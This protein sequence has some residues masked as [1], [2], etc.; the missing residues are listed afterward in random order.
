[1]ARLRA[2]V[3]SRIGP[4]GPGGVAARGALLM[5]LGWFTLRH[6]ADRDFRGI[7]AGL[8][9]ALHEAGHLVFGWFGSE[10]LAAAG[11]TLFHLLC[12]GAV[13]VA[14]W[15]QRDVFAVAVAVWWSGTLFLEA[16]PYAA[17]ARAQVLPLVTVGDGPVGHDWFMILE[18]LGLLAADG[19]VGETFR[20]LG[21]GLL[22]AGV[23]GGAWVVARMRALG[24]AS[25]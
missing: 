19:I 24:T 18:P 14:F 7:Y 11:G 17:D 21:L 12:I 10:W 4:A 16:A 5:V 13:G 8:N 3:E 2:A 22:V 9:L 1:M 15:R 23:A 25:G 6:L 20:L